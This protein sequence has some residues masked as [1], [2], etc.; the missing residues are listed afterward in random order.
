M[1]W[2]SSVPSFVLWEQQRP[3]NVFDYLLNPLRQC[4]VFGLGFSETIFICWAFS[5]QLKKKTWKTSCG[6]LYNLLASLYWKKHC[7]IFLIHT[8]YSSPN[9]FLKT[10]S[11]S[12]FFSSVVRFSRAVRNI[13]IC[14]FTI[15]SH[16]VFSFW[17]LTHSFK[18]SHLFSREL[19]HRCRRL[20]WSCSQWPWHQQENVTSRCSVC[21]QPAQ[22]R[23]A[24][25]HANWRDQTSWN[26]PQTVRWYFTECYLY[27]LPVFRK[28]KTRTNHTGL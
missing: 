13:P 14:C 27:N 11:I 6:S 20:L 15:S 1:N 26:L 4:S 10:S 2:F 28:R 25:V 3:Q 18:P 24:S 12:Y 9:S 8:F 23:P 16:S 5:S 22:G 17:I 7:L 21:I 19:A